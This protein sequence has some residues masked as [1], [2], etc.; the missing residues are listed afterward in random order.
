MFFISLHHVRASRSSDG[1]FCLL[2]AHGVLH[3][4]PG[5]RIMVL[6]WLRA[7]G[8]KCVDTSQAF[9]WLQVDSSLEHIKF[10]IGLD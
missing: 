7:D 10:H 4:T 2:M 3:Y 6:L 1:D 8:G 9:I 5:L